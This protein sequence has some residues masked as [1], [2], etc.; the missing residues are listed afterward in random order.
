MACTEKY[1][2]CNPNL[3]SSHPSR[4]ACTS[5][6]GRK[7][8]RLS[9]PNIGL[10]PAQLAT[11]DLITNA[12]VH[13]SIYESIWDSSTLLAT[14]TV[15]DSMYQAQLPDNQWTAEVANWFAVGLARLQYTVLEYTTGPEYSNGTD[16]LYP[17]APAAQN[18]CNTIKLRN[19]GN[20]MSFSVLGLA[21][22][23]FFGLFIII[24]S[25]VLEPLTFFFSK[26]CRNGKDDYRRL[27]WVLD[28]KLQLQRMA[29]ECSGVGS[30]IWVWEKKDG[31]VP[32]TVDETKVTRLLDDVDGEQAAYCCGNGA[33]NELRQGV[34]LN[35]CTN[36][37]KEH[38]NRT[39]VSWQLNDTV[40]L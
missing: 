40:G 28:G 23:F 35:Y 13:D 20:Y 39:L 10:N 1:Q 8:L 33:G 14:E 25:I 38:R 34:R 30:G 7:N 19:P 22:I 32:V 6:H 12:S 4:D 27:Q 36:K 3:I 17:N 9:S 18:L 21:V 11:A 37:S 26:Y 31:H 29:Y 2:L 16:V 24:M 5:L 15:A